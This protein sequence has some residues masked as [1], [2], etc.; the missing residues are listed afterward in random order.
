MSVLHTTNRNGTRLSDGQI[1][2]IVGDHRAGRSVSA[3][4]KRLGVSRM[5]VYRQLERALPSKAAQSSDV[6]VYSRLS[7]DDYSALR[8][9][10]SD[11][12][13]SV[14]ALSRHV[15]RRAA[16]FFDAD[17]EIAA[18][19]LELSN[20]LKKIGTNLNQ[21]VHQINREAI[22]QGR[23]EP[24]SEHVGANR[25]LLQ[26]VATLKEGWIPARLVLRAVSGKR[27]LGVTLPNLRLGLRSRIPRRGRRCGTSLC[28]P[29]G[30]NLHCAEFL[31]SDV[32]MIVFIVQS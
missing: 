7:A 15:L 31:T 11:R 24:S 8:S 2:A 18:A 22:L 3:I 13:E 12:G 1:A 16:G 25:P 10:A 26:S 6:R 19:A 30:R 5:T 23:G 9:L 32:R 27:P 21:V 4:A 14:A 20:E 17:R 28:G 29:S